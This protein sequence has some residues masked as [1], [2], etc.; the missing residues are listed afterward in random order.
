MAKKA[1]VIGKVRRSTRYKVVFP[2]SST[3]VVQPISVE[4]VQEQYHHDVLVLNYANTY[5][6]LFSSLKTGVPVR[7]E[8]KQG[9]QTK[10]WLG[11]VSSITRQR[12]SERSRPMQVR[13]VGATFLMKSK[14][15]RVFKNVTI[16]DVAAKI[17][18]ENGMQFVG[19]A[20]GVRYRQISISG[21]SY[22]EW[23]MENA[24]KIGY[25]V[26]ADGTSLHFQRADRVIDRGSTNAPV[27][28]FWGVT[29]PKSEF[30][31][32]RTLDHFKITQTEY[33]ETGTVSRAT[34]VVGGTHPITGK[35]FVKKSS[36][37]KVG[38]KMRKVVDDVL[39]NEPQTSTVID[40]AAKAVGLSK[41]AANLARFTLPADLAGQGDPRIHPF[42]VVH[43]NG[44]GESTDGYW[45]V[46]ECKH[47][48]TATGEYTVTASVLSDG[49]GGN[50]AS[51]IRKDELGVVGRINTEDIL[52]N[53]P[54]ME[55]GSRG[56]SIRRVSLSGNSKKSK[57]KLFYPGQA[58]TGQ[59]KALASSRPGFNRTP[60]RWRS[61]SPTRYGK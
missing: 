7:F 16:S 57:N 3:I 36:P 29:L 48:F 10:E 21:Q 46:K 41:G 13:C 52:A 43:V 47:M 53:S 59:T 27:M 50:K 32:D 31:L 19:D 44:T 51:G 25:V 9:S 30:A 33:D 37:A 8:W 11:Y 54:E 49:L 28:Q 58:V 45:L 23:L 20:H 38:K 4:L 60:A 1:P 42:G 2:L 24:K 61:S 22:W 6:K 18:K 17:A 35:K 12:G 56:T 14:Q 5:E 34:K 15:S 39:F 26:Y 40:G 55:G